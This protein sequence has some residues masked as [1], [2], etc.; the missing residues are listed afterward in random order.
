MVGEARCY[1]QVTI[2][3]IAALLIS[4]LVGCLI[5][6]FVYGRAVTSDIKD[7]TRRFAGKDEYLDEISKHPDSYQ[8]FF[9]KISEVAND[10]LWAKFIL[11]SKFVLSEEGIKQIEEEEKKTDPILKDA[12]EK[13]LS[14]IVLLVMYLQY[15]TADPLFDQDTKKSHWVSVVLNRDSVDSFPHHNA[16]VQYLEKYGYIG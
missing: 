1:Y 4:V 9:E 16:I 2:M 5:I 7:I 3:E 13:G 12:T 6:Y 10:N 8:Y 14:Q 11:N 15:A